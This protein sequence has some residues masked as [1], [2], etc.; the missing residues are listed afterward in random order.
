MLF[1]DNSIFF[2]SY[3]LCNSVLSVILFAMNVSVC[4]RDSIHSAHAAARGCLSVRLIRFDV[5]KTTKR[6]VNILALSVNSG[7][8]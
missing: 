8:S 6:V 3:S 5:V 4:Q 2:N 1:T 7:Y